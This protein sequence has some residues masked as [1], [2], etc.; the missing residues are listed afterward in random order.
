MFVRFVLAF[1]AFLIVSFLSAFALMEIGI[2]SGSVGRLL[3]IGIVF[4][5]GSLVSSRIL[6]PI[7]RKNTV[8]AFFC[9]VELI[10]LGGLADD[11]MRNHE[12]SMHAGELVMQSLALATSL[13][14]LRSQQR[15]NGAF[16]GKPS[17]NQVK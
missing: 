10:S 6:P 1:G 4:V 17:P 12:Y 8:I 16:P 9:I 5:F 2:T 13:R 11:L 3:S 15:Q 14:V 7:Y